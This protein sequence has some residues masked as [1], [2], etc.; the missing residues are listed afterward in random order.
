MDKLILT[1]CDDVLLN[2][3]LGFKNFCEIEKGVKFSSAE[4][5]EWNL[6][7]WVGV[8]D[9]TVGEWIHQFNSE[10]WEFGALPAFHDALVNIPKLTA[11]DYRFIC[12]TS[13]S[14]NS[15]VVKL[16]RA[17]LFMMFGDIFDE[18]ICLPLG[19]SKGTVLSKYSPTFWIEDNF[20]NGIVGL[21]HGHKTIMMRRNHN[22]RFE[23]NSDPRIIWCSSWGEIADCI[24]NEQQLANQETLS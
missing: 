3:S 2:W 12:I 13:C 20:T 8:P 14:D 21:E 15:S 7:S 11:R 16:R 22:R 18:V 4:P 5:D 23:K 24:I 1:D 9:H 19:I 6:T 10:S 17:N